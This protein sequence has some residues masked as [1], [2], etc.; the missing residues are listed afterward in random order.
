[1]PMRGTDRNGADLF[2]LIADIVIAR[3]ASWRDDAA[4]RGADIDLFFPKQTIP[5]GYAEAKSLCAQCSVIG[6]CREEW[7][8]MPSAM[9]R[10]GVWFGTTDKERRE[11]RQV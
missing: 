5:S 1:M 3:E 10:H 9:Q 4:C 2:D 8:R 11:S 7:E 6:K